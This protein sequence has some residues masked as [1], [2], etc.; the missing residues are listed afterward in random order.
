M[1]RETRES[2]EQEW[3]ISQQL[4]GMI[5]ALQ[6]DCVCARREGIRLSFFT[7]ISRLKLEEKNCN[8][9]V[10]PLSLLPNHNTNSS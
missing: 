2:N 6:D 10:L 5:E 1:Y 7:K 3:G 4:P 9:D 8:T